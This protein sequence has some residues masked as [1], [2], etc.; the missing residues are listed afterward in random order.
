MLQQKKIRIFLAKKESG[1]RDLLRKDR[2]PEWVE[3]PFPI[4]FTYVTLWFIC[5]PA[6]SVAT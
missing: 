4:N 5:I 2:S 3:V 1:G 6:T